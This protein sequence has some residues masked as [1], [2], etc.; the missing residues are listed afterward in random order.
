[1]WL[2]FVAWLE[3]MRNIIFI[4]LNS[5]AIITTIFRYN[6]FHKFLKGWFLIG[7]SVY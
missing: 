4:F 6:G 7:I 1:M 3:Q 5:L 2:E